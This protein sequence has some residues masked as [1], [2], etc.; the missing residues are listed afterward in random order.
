M[1]ESCIE[2]DAD[3]PVV[4]ASESRICPAGLRACR[5]Y[6]P[7]T[8]G[9]PVLNSPMRAILVFTLVFVTLAA[10]A[11][12]AARPPQDSAQVRQRPLHARP[13][14]TAPAAGDIAT[15][16]GTG[17][18]GDSGD[19]GSAL[20]AKIGDPYGEVFDAS[21][22][23]YFA[24]YAYCVVRK[25]DA[26]TGVITTVAGKAGSA[27]DSG[28]NGL[29][30]SAG[31]DYPTSLA[32]DSNGN[33][34]IG[35]YQ[36]NRI[37]MVAAATGIITT[38]AGTGKA[39]FFGDSGMATAA[40][41]Y[42][43]AGIAFDSD[44]NLYISDSDNDRIRKITANAGDIA[45]GTITTVAGT[46]STAG[47]NGDG[48]L[49]TS[50]NLENPSG[51]AVDA[52]GN[53]YFGEYNDARV[54]K[55]TKSTGLISTIAGTGTEGDTASTAGPTT[56]ANTV[57][58]DFP[59][60][61]ALDS[62]GN[63]YFADAVDARVDKVDATTGYFS[64]VAGTGIKGFTA[65]G[66]A[67]SAQLNFPDGVVLDANGNVFIS[68]A[69]NYLI[70]EVAPG[71]ST[72]TLTP[73]FSPLPGTFN[74]GQTVQILDQSPNAVI[75]YTIDGATPTTSS[76]V[77]SAPVTVDSTITI[78]AIAVA[79]GLTQS[80]VGSGVFTVDVPAAAPVFS[81][82]GGIFTSQVN[83]TIKDATPNSTIFWAYGG[84]PAEIPVD[85]YDAPI[86][87]QGFVTVYAFAVAPGYLNSPTV[88]ATFEVDPAAPAPTFKPA[89]GTFSTT[90]MVTLS[91][92]Q[93]A[94][95]IYYT[96]DG[97]TP[98]TSSKVYSGPLT[99]SATETIQ[100]IAFQYG[101]FTPSAVAAGTYKI[102]ATIAT[103]P[104][105]SPAGGTFNAPQTVTISDTMSGVTIYYTTDGSTP[106]TSST[107]YTGTITVSSSETINAIAAISGLPNS[108]V[109]TATFKLVAATPTLTPPPGTYTSAQTVTIT[110]STPG[111]TIHYT[112]NQETPTTSSPVYTGPI[113]VSSTEYVLALAA[114]TGYTTSFVAGSAYTI[115][116]PL[117]TPT[118]APAGGAYSS[119]QQVAIS[120]SVRGA[121][122]YYTTDGSTPTTAS[123]WYS[124]PITV[125]SSETIK[126]IAVMSGS[127]NS[128]VG[129]AVYTINLATLP[130]PTFSPKAGTYTSQQSVSITESTSGATVYYTTNGTTPTTASLK[131][132]GPITVSSKETIQAIATL[133]GYNNSPVASA[134]YTI[135]LPPAAT[136]TFS[137]P[138]GAYSS[139]QRVSISDSTSGATIYYTTDGSTPTTSSTLY[140]GTFLVPSTETVKAIAIVPGSYSISPVA[141]AVYTITLSPA[142]T[143][144]F[145]LI[146]GAYTTP[147]TEYIF[148]STTGAVIYYTTDGATPTTGSTKYTGS[149]IVSVTETIQ[150]IAVAPG[151]ANS[152]VAKAI[153]T[154]ESVAATPVITP[155]GGPYST[156][157]SVTITDT[158]PGATIYYTTN[159]TKPT[160]SSTKYTGSI[161]VSS[162]ET[163]E[164]VAIATGYGISAVASAAYTIGAAAATPTFSPAAGAYSGTQTVTISD[165]T[166]GAVIYYT[167]NSSTPT[168]GSTRYTSPI[169]V[170]SSQTVEAIAVAAGYLNSPV[171]SASYTINTAP[172]ISSVSAILAEQTQTITITGSGFGANSPYSGNSPYIAFDDN[173]GVVWGAGNG[174]DAVGLNVTSWTN[175]Q[176]V[177]AGL[178]GA[179]GYNNWQMSNGDHI[180]LIV[181]NPQTGAGPYTCSNIVVNNGPTTCTS[182][183]ASSRPAPLT[184]GGKQLRSK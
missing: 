24:D 137:L 49:A 77:Y 176:I 143:P 60:Q 23:L 171:A 126:A 92:T 18:L 108:T 51:I 184:S 180:T 85:G 183:A 8:G 139:A 109:A 90:Q 30:T 84:P 81:P 78:K 156:A 11:N 111:V 22:N 61:V 21:G 105:I 157:Q 73:Y 89:P 170:S 79:P 130:A 57:E 27:V 35:E 125:S 38:V 94:A 1:L 129:S 169:T 63:V 128:A 56:L 127:T 164:A 41:F 52:A 178:T 175:N 12:A 148:D 80:L 101:L 141:T 172:G 136:P 131:Y 151:Y 76:T 118:F 45:T 19:N 46:G 34:Y 10:G 98:T 6:K 37:R 113:T 87:I 110:D 28:D 5:P 135:N 104:T 40:E 71:T 165:T 16:A 160:A 68:D 182:G 167:T 102:Q 159:G 39:G 25:I 44:G 181:Y 93:S 50:A 26:T 88:K 120:D 168:P 48:I 115:N 31:L 55:V 42:H 145:Y 106:T 62:A 74:S 140:T 64:V 91:D 97:S 112:L 13:L 147:Q 153:F 54:R 65:E 152:A 86:P 4:A 29:A 67:L 119:I 177:I 95:T 58:I 138:A 122:I 154:I 59:E 33:L 70:R 15:V 146:G 142:A 43:P 149:F 7:L 134:A 116:T 162:S 66:P 17:K 103:A 166:P 69:G 100:A 163:I 3:L 47:Y 114:E 9:R 158:T 173:S 20:D 132:T 83:L 144:I 107:K 36:G 124:A 133:A 2:L 72:Q 123:T 82:D 117:P 121:N 155:A 161:T 32:F 150:A 179:Y 174:G 53:I 96:T 99:V 75:Y 14:F